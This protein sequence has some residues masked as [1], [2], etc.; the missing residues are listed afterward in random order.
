M[1]AEF[2]RVA[3]FFLLGLII[4]FL[5]FARGAAFVIDGYK[6]EIEELKSDRNGKESK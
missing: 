1:D 2:W 4:G 6:E 3:A 5:I